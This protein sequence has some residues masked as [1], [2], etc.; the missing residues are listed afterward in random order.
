MRDKI[1]LD[2]IT[3]QRAS[4]MDIET[5]SPIKAIPSSPQKQVVY[6]ISGTPPPQTPT[7]KGSCDALMP[8]AIPTGEG[9]GKIKTKVKYLSLQG[10]PVLKL[11]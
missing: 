10:D 1:F 3:H 7:R 11:D 5:L 4:A 2:V 6:P 9:A 8:S